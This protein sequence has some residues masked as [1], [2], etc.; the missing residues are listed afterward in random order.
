MID[1]S[2]LTP[3]QRELAKRIFRK[4]AEAEAK[5]HGTTIEKVHFH[6]VGAVDSIAD[7]VGSA[8][9]W[10]LL[11]V[12]R[13]VCSPVPTGTR[14]RRDR[15]RPVL[16]SRAGDGRAAARRA[17]GRLR[18]RGRADDADRRGD[19]R[20]AGRRVR[21]AAGD[22]DRADRLRRRAEGFSR[23]RICCGCSSARPLGDDAGGST[24][25][26][27]I[28][29]LETNLDDATGES[30]GYCIERLWTGRRPGRVD[31][32]A[33]DEEESAGRAA[34]SAVPAGGRR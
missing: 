12:E 30:I 27:T 19:R 4:L 25:A 24:V 21:P 1:G 11:G 28:V 16:D 7:I 34:G 22:D 18:R 13:I 32:A 6:E 31:H 29:L 3:R 15:P 2:T 33:G 26:D 8:I 5:V 9:A 10:D 17:A 14:L 23:S 20:G